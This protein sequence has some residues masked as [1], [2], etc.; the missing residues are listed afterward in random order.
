MKK[1]VVLVFAFILLM[2]FAAVPVM[3]DALVIHVYPGQSIQ[4]A[5]DEAS[6]GAIIIVHEGTYYR[7]ITIDKELTLI[8]SGATIS[9][10][11]GPFPWGVKVIAGGVKI[12][13][14]TI[15]NAAQAGIHLEGSF[16][17]CRID[18]NEISQC[19]TGIYIKSASNVD[20]KDNEIHAFGHAIT[21]DSGSEISIKNNKI[22]AGSTYSGVRFSKS[23]S[24]EVKGN[25]VYTSADAVYFIQGSDVAIKG[26]I[27]QGR[28][29]GVYIFGMS[30]A[31]MG[32]AEVVD[33]VIFTSYDSSTLVSS[34]IVLGWVNNAAVIGNEVLIGANTDPSG[35]GITLVGS[36][37]STVRD[38][39]VSGDFMKGIAISGTATYYSTANTVID[40]IVLGDDRTGNVGIYFNTFTSGNIVVNNI[41]S[42][43]SLPIQDDSGLNTILP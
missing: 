42:G 38:N 10:A 28:F 39:S 7:S 9:A 15:T 14:F 30:T 19:S 1:I 8:G 32:D 13:G 12:S 6:I 24:V 23:S 34:G 29:H 2:T 43:V 4:D 5:I 26:N 18:N 36:T 37:G 31:T 16:S 3:A 21:V 33:N 35:N 41:I 27:L 20:I 25:T 11:V 17:G 22:W 40:D